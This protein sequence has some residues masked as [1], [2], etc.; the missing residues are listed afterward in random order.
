MYVPVARMEGQR[1]GDAMPAH[2]RQVGGN[3]NFAMREA[4]RVAEVHQG[5]V[6]RFLCRKQR[7]QVRS[8]RDPRALIGCAHPRY[9]TFPAMVFRNDG[10]VQIDDIVADRQDAHACHAPPASNERMRYW[11]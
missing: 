3:Q 8:A 11:K 4:W 10:I 6:S 1:Q 7:P 2:G 9:E 5:F